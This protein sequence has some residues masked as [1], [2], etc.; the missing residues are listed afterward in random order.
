MNRTPPPDPTM[1]PAAPTPIIRHIIA[2]LRSPKRESVALELPPQFQ[3]TAGTMPDLDLIQWIADNHGDPISCQYLTTAISIQQPWAWAILHAGKDVENRSRIMAKTGW[4]YLHAGQTLE[5]FNYYRAANIIQDLGIEQ[6]PD[7]FKPS[8]G[9]FKPLEE[10]KLPREMPAA[11]KLQTGGIIGA[12]H[13]ERWTDTSQSPWF[14]GPKAAVITA[15]LPL[16]FIPCLGKLGAFHPT[17]P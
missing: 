3:R 5:M 13:I 9:Q 6:D 12:F 11:D 8:D 17:I 10:S 2:N 15:A 7:E 1:K 4:H 16:A 14:F